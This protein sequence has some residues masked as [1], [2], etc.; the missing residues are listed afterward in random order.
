MAGS[1]PKTRTEWESPAAVTYRCRPSAENARSLALLRP[2]PASRRRSRWRSRFHK[3]GGQGCMC[4]RE[5]NGPEQCRSHRR[6]TGCLPGQAP[7]GKRPGDHR[8][9]SCKAWPRVVR[10]DRRFQHSRPHRMPCR[11]NPER[12]AQAPATTKCR[13]RHR[14]PSLRPRPPG[15]CSQGRRYGRSRRPSDTVQSQSAV[16]SERSNLSLR[17]EPPVLSDAII[18]A[19]LRRDVQTLSWLTTTGLPSAPAIE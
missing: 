4:L 8:R 12:T 9:P 13:G 6:H 15:A 5:S 17:E 16:L 18:I 19:V 7:S 14:R 1:R 11:C 2:R 10:I 3:R